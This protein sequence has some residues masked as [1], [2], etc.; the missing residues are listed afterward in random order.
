[1]TLTKYKAKTNPGIPGDN[2]D[3]ERPHM[4]PITLVKGVSKLWNQTD[5]KANMIGSAKEFVYMTF[6]WAHWILLMNYQVVVEANRAYLVSRISVLSC[7]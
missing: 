3:E 2:L 6:L 1:M 7:E 4:A 5:L